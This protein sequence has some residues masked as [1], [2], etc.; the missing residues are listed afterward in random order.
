MKTL[1]NAHIPLAAGLL[2]LGSAGA[3]AQDAGLSVQRFQ[4]QPGAALN[5]NHVEGAGVLSHLQPAFGLSVNYAYRP[6]TLRSSTGETSQILL[7]YDLAADVTAAVGLFDWVQL[8][9]AV[10]YTLLQ[11]Q[12]DLSALG[13]DP[14]ATSALGDIRAVLRLKLYKSEDFRLA[15]SIP[16]GLD[17][18]SEADLHGEQ[19]MTYEPRLLA[20][21]TLGD[22]RLGGQ[23]GYKI[24]PEGTY[25][26]LTYASELT[27]GGGVELTV[28]PDRLSLVG[29][30]FGNLAPATTNG[31]LQGVAALEADLG[32]RYL[33]G[34]GHSLGVS[35]GA[36]LVRG[37]GTPLLRAFMGYGFT[38][39]RV[40][41][42]KDSD[43]DG[44]VDL[45]DGC[46]AEPEDL[47]QHEDSNGCPDP[48]NDQ[49]GVL[50]NADRCPKDPEDKDSF[51][52]DDGCPD[53]DNDQDGVK[54]IDDKCPNSLEDRDGFS[55]EDGCLDPDN[56][57]DG[58]LDV[59]DG[60]PL[61]P[62][63]MDSLGDED[64]C[65][66]ADFDKDGLTDEVDQCPRKPE[67][68]NGIKD[69]DGCPDE[70]KGSVEV[71]AG[72]I[73]LLDKVYFASDKT[74][75]LPRSFPVLKQVIAVLKANP[76]ITKLQINGHTDNQGDDDYNLKLSQGRVDA[77]MKFLVEGGIEAGRLAAVGYGEQKHIAPNET[78]AGRAKNRRVEFQIMEVD[79][80][81][82]A[83]TTQ[84]ESPK[85]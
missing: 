3:Q 59:Q 24:R 66:E 50:D 67:T 83:P 33:L 49:D 85:P 11:S 9:I 27:F 44:L 77:V 56:D 39:K 15:L 80:K 35:V 41:K 72:K 71:K 32:G 17:T 12:P 34:N 54:D 51:Q 62:E 22:L 40:E 18:G 61:Q 29:E 79:G 23:V 26:Q 14:V 52:D 76:Q 37:Y 2:L 74:D 7:D 6:L 57:L 5:F 25:L 4:P 82:V 31:D 30:L 64:G 55:D 16:V 10:P 81:A 20:E 70:G 78:E 28:V 8:G 53:T 68:I 47:D 48:D 58:L 65:P 63:D 38:P 19:G 1:F 69:E 84:I 21:G 36:G 46:P 43:G 42:P 75:I 13:L 73:E 45:Q 60:C